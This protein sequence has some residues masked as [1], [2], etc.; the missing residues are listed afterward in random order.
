MRWR[1]QI[2]VRP[3]EQVR[4]GIFIFVLILFISSALLWSF[5]YYTVS[6]IEDSISPKT[7]QLLYPLKEKIVEMAKWEFTLLIFAALLVG[8]GSGIIFSHAFLG[9]LYRLEKHLREWDGKKPL[10]KISF[11]KSDLLHFI[12]HAF[13]SAL[14]KCGNKN[15]KD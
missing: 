14:E 2:L 11:R 10:K 4:V 15:R 1:R 5:F 8:I 3:R 13:N 9:P 6:L 7:V 12:A